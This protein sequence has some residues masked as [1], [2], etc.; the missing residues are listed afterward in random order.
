MQKPW[1]LLK[2]S[3]IKHAMVTPSHL[4][5]LQA[6]ELAMRRGS[7]KDAADALAITPAA[8]GQRI[9]ALEEYLG[10]PL[11]DRGRS[12][13]APSPALAAAL[14][15]LRQAFAALEAAAVELDL[16]R[17]HELH[18]AATSDFAELWL[19]PRMADYRAT[20]PNIRFCINGE[21]DVP[22]R[23]GRVD[24]EIAY[25]PVP[26]DPLVDLL[27]HD[28]VVPIASRGTIERIAALPARN[29][30]EGYPLLHFDFYKD[31]PAG[32]S[33]P[34]WIA[35]TATPRTAPERGMRFQRITAGIDAVLAN[36]GVG[37]CGL[38]LIAEAVK[39]GAIALPYPVSTAIRGEHAF[40]ARFRA[41][42]AARPHVARFRSWLS[43]QSQ[44]TGAWLQS[45]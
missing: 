7:L 21:G 22:M 25:G 38:G 15:H 41:D 17:G 28:L 43:E 26:D 33:W 35:A 16:Q 45:L 36:S 3:L 27:F 34:R 6:L 10:V 31:D 9:K 5:A 1:Q 30:L 23:L 11:L 32:L 19:A 29:D 37:L 2:L 13:L 8:V 44:A 18:I 24:C 14:P 12:G 42:A 39:A 40:H 20:H 4:K